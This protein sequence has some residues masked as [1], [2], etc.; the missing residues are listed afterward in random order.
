M[1]GPSVYSDKIN[2]YFFTLLVSGNKREDIPFGSF[3]GSG[4]DL[5]Y[6][7]TRQLSKKKFGKMRHLKLSN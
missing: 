4:L 1:P 6:T 5:T 3:G 2:A 7:L